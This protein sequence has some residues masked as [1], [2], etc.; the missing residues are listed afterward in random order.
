MAEDQ[1]RLLERLEDFVGDRQ[2]MGR[3]VKVG[4]H[5]QELIAA[6]AADGVAGADAAD[7]TPRRNPQE[8]VT[9]G[10]APACR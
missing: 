7:Q 4:Q 10:V 2:R 8:V 6:Q 3:V 9:V 5:D 1:E